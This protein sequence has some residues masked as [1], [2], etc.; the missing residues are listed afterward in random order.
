MPRSRAVPPDDDLPHRGQRQWLTR[1][2]AQARLEGSTLSASDVIRYALT[3]LQ[4]CLFEEELREA[5]INHV[6][7]EAKLYPGVPEGD[8][9]P[10]QPRMHQAPDRW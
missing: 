8:C 2:A 9:H 4:E 7:S 6:H 10:I 3:S 1:L 5:V